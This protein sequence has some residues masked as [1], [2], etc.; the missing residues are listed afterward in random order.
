YLAHGSQQAGAEVNLEHE[1]SRRGT[2]EVRILRLRFLDQEGKPCRAVGLGQALTVE[3][4]LAARAPLSALVAG[5]HFI[6]F[7][8]LPVLDIRSDR[9]HCLFHAG[10]ERFTIRCTI[11]TVPLYPGRYTIDPWIGR[12]GSIQ[13]EV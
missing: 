9:Q 6:R 4:D 1:S 10:A 7:D 13:N 8:G 3:V 12:A 2:G 5:V 11:P